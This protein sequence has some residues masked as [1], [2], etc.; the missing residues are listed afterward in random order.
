MPWYPDWVIALHEASASDG[1]GM[2]H[3]RPIVSP[4]HAKS[5]LDEVMRLRGE[6]ADRD[7]AAGIEHEPVTPVNALRA[8]VAARQAPVWLRPLQLAI[9][10]AGR[11]PNVVLA[12]VEAERIVHEVI[13]IGNRTTN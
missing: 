4:S 11:A 7:A 12:R 8:M 2:R 9:R 10:V 3:G 13:R 1:D 5:A 6:L